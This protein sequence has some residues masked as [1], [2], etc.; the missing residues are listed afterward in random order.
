[1]TKENVVNILSAESQH[2]VWPI[3]G[4]T[5]WVINDR[6]CS[7]EVVRAEWRILLDVRVNERVPTG[8]AEAGGV[9][10]GRFGW[11]RV[12]SGR[13]VTRNTVFLCAA[14]A[15]APGVACSS[16]VTVQGQS[17]ALDPATYLPR[18]P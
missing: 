7:A 4:V 2:S 17:P 18:A 12:S 3:L 16:G 9:R 8:R 10:E 6:R 13:G 11:A 14:A 5:L 1:M 15:L